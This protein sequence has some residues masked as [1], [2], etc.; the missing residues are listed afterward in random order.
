MSSTDFPRL[1]EELEHRILA[2]TGRRVRNLDINL[3]L[4][5]VI[6]KGEAQTFYVKQLAQQGVREVLPD[7]HLDNAIQVA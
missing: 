7:V 5:G 4:E 1:R 3:S 2:L 6:L